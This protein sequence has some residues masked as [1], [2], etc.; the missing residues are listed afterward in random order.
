MAE[1][2]SRLSGE[3]SKNCVCGGSARAC[4]IKQRVEASELLVPNASRPFVA[5]W[6]ELHALD[7]GHIVLA[8]LAVSQVVGLARQ[9]EIAEPVVRFDPVD[10]VDLEPVWYGAVAVNPCQPV[11]QVVAPTDVNGVVPKGNIERAA[12]QPV[13]VCLRPHSG[14]FVPNKNARCGIKRVDSFDNFLRNLSGGIHTKQL[15]EGAFYG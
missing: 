1:K 2:L 6:I 14:S 15:Y 5:G 4:G 13:F 3:R 10:V 11:G 9:P 8:D 12:R 7:A